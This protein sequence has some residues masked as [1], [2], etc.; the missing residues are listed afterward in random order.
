M[1]DGVDQE[2]WTV[3]SSGSSETD[4]SSFVQVSVSFTSVQS[5][6]TEKTLFTEDP[7]M[8]KPAQEGKCL[9]AQTGAFQRKKEPESNIND[10][11]VP[12]DALLVIPEGNAAVPKTQVWK[13][14]I[15]LL[16]STLT[17]QDRSAL[18]T[19]ATERAIKHVDLQEKIQT[20]NSLQCFRSVT[21]SNSKAIR[22]ATQVRRT[23]IME[24]AI[25]S[26]WDQSSPKNKSRKKKVIYMVD[27]PDAI[28]DIA[29]SCFVNRI[30]N[31]KLLVHDSVA[32]NND[33]HIFL[34]D[35]NSSSNFRPPHASV[36]CINSEASAVRALEKALSRPVSLPSQE[37]EAYQSILTVM[38]RQ[39]ALMKKLRRPS[40]GCC[41]RSVTWRGE[42][43]KGTVRKSCNQ[44][45]RPKHDVLNA[46]GKTCD[47]VSES[48]SDDDDSCTVGNGSESD[49]SL[50][51][52]NTSQD[53]CC[54]DESGGSSLNSPMTT[55]SSRE[56]DNKTINRRN[57]SFDDPIDSA[58]F[59]RGSLHFVDS[60]EVRRMSTT[61]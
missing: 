6:T 46:S 33:T 58:W 41:D 18:L 38:D 56:S 52:S 50:H 24:E 19:M 5:G 13:K 26:F 55:D 45:E 4:D 43:E 40:F 44:M 25:R 51:N 7:I 57:S 28:D 54:S 20:M 35:A 16:L 23:A 61:T 11:R 12:F 2:E 22:V 9:I 47:L 30:L 29:L 37:L 17:D 14:T 42:K 49:Y 48:E 15:L 10:Y 34:M 32:D 21:D 8:G 39:D 60:M 31:H 36:H 1:V 53:S 3:V 27:A 59:Q